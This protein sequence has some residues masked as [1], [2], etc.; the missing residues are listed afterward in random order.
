MCAFI[1][2]NKNTRLVIILG[3]EGLCLVGRNGRIAFDEDS[4]DTTNNFN[5]LGEG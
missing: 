5:T 4:H 3:H 1:N 2:V